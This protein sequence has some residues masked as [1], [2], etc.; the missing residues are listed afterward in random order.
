MA[1]TLVLSSLFILRALLAFAPRNLTQLEK[2]KTKSKNKMS[3]NMF[4]M[5]YGFLAL[6]LGLFAAIREVGLQRGCFSGWGVS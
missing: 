2:G 3:R 6:V 5:L 1:K 4:F